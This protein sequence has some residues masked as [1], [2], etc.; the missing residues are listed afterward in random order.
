MDRSA[1]SSRGHLPA[2]ANDVGA[3]LR[4]WRMARRL[5]QL[6]LA[7]DAGISARHLSCIETG[8]AHPTRE[9]VG[10]LADTLAVPLRERNALLLAA[11]FSPEYPERP[12]DTPELAP[13]RRAIDCI[14]EHQEPYPAFVLNR[15]W[16]ILQT[17]RAATR[18]GS[19]LGS[20]RSHTNMVRRFFDPNGLR[21]VVV[22]WEEVAQDLIRHLHDAVAAVRSDTRTRGLLEEVLRYPGVPPRWRMRELG[23]TPT[24]LLTVAFRKAGRDLRFFSTITAFATPRDVTL[25][26]L[27]I[28]CSFP[29]DDATAE[30]CGALARDEAALDRQSG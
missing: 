11:G 3:L 22:N 4:E 13:I 27:R 8:K 25:D 12:L 5:S 2:S 28:E 30:F 7:L 6:D 9:M 14:L 29:A 16:D 15:C 24:P 18:L 26:D 20:G 23:V 19:F 10:R 1:S 21:A 17:N